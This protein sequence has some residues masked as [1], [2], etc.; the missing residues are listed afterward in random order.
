VYNKPIEKLKMVDQIRIQ[1]YGS[2]IEDILSGEISLDRLYTAQIQKLIAV[3][4]RQK[5]VHYRYA[6]LHLL[7]FFLDAG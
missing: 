6:R 2:E 7:S 4:P 5:V 1:E 3:S